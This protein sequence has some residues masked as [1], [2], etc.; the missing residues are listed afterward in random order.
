MRESAL[1][2]KLEVIMRFKTVKIDYW[3]DTD[4]KDFPNIDEFCKS[5]DFNYFLKVNKKRTDS[6]GGG[7]YELVI[8]ITEDL[9]LMAVAQSYLQDGVKAIINK[10]IKST[11]ENLKILFDKNKDLSPTVDTLILDY[12]DCKIKIYRLFSKSIE[13]VIDELGDEICKFYLNHP[14]AFKDIKKIHI[15]ILNHKD[16]YEL[17]DYRVKLNYDEPIME[18][19][20][21]DYFKFWGLTTSSGKKVYDLSK[22][23]I[24]DQVFYTQK[25]YDRLFDAKYKKTN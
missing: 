1:I 5:V 11:L 10:T 21:D 2:H 22:D 13:S 18:F 4:G 19:H 24:V 8:R 14:D 7:L 25:S 6:L 3:V 9:T 17:C 16:S 20:K 15:P 12:N 23:S